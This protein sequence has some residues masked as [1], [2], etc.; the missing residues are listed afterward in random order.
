MV[1]QR[2]RRDYQLRFPNRSIPY[3]SAFRNVRCD[4]TLVTC[5]SYN[6]YSTT[7]PTLVRATITML[8]CIKPKE[9]V[10]SLQIVA[11][12]FFFGTARQRRYIAGFVFPSFFSFGSTS[13]AERA[14]R[15]LSIISRR[16]LYFT[17]SAIRTIVKSER[18]TDV[19]ILTVV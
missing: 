13:P 10:I 5:S 14:R 15:S 11:V 7:R 17:I 1:T 16:G 4:N 18:S 3:R 19:Y 12:Y 2:S 9:L 8:R 6:S